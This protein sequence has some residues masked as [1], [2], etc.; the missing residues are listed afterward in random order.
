MEAPIYR[1]N[2]IIA[3]KSATG[4]PHYSLVNST[5]VELEYL[6]RYFLKEGTAHSLHKSKLK[7]PPQANN[8][9]ISFDNYLAKKGLRLN[10][11]GLIKLPSFDARNQAIFEKWVT[12]TV[13]VL[14]GLV[15]IASLV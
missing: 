5:Y 3:C 15:A 2:Y 11:G 1:E 7:D 4:K 8:K 10:G 13:F 14:L 9:V 6:R 12:I